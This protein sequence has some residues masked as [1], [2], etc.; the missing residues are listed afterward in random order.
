MDNKNIFDTKIN[1]EITLSELENLIIML[2]VANK[3]ITGEIRS[4]LEEKLENIAFK[5]KTNLK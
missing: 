2:R 5:I 3:V 1:V 4:E